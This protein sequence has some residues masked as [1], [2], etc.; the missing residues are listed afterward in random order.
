MTISLLIMTIL[1]KKK[2]KKT[3]EH[4]DFFLS[5]LIS[6]LSSKQFQVYHKRK[7]DLAYKEQRVKDITFPTVKS[8]LRRLI[9]VRVLWYGMHNHSSLILLVHLSLLIHRKVEPLL[10]KVGLLFLTLGG[11]FHLLSKRIKQG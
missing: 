1:Q 10:L 7:T 5:T 11:L 3:A 6:K 2:Q 4:T 8:D 9:I